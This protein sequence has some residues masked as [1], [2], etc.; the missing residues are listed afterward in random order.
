MFGIALSKFLVPSVEG[1]TAGVL[2]GDWWIFNEGNFL[3]GMKN[4]L[5]NFI[6]P[7]ATDREIANESDS[8]IS[9]LVS[10]ISVAGTSNSTISSSPPSG[11]SEPSTPVSATLSKSPTTVS[12]VSE[13]SALAVV[14]SIHQNPNWLKDL[15]TNFKAEIVDVCSSKS[16][17][18]AENDEYI[19]VT[20]TELIIILHLKFFQDEEEFKRVR[21]EILNSAMKY[22]KK[23][24]GG[25][26]NPGTVYLL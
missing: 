1:F 10:N 17:Q 23:V 20:R 14:A 26:K 24:F 25:T 15:K 12:P 4:K 21:N 9:E 7:D 8:K 13:N 5:H 19:E 11:L 3:R 2:Q 6:V 18:A 16:K 22:L